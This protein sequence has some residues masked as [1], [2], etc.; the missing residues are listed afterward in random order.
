MSEFRMPSLGADM[1]SGTL[2]EW[3]IRPGERV[4]RGQ[5]VCVVET[6][7]GAIDVEI[8]ETGTVER[9]VAEEGQKVPV[10]EVLAVIIAEGE[11]AEG[12]KA[13]GEAAGR[14]TP[15]EPSIPE[16]SRTPS[17][18]APSPRALD[19][20]PPVPPHAAATSGRL[21]ISPAA[22]KRAAELGLDPADV[23]GSGVDGSITLEDVERA[24]RPAEG[25]Q[26]ALSER[27]AD[28]HAA[29][30][31]AIAT[32]MARSKREIPHYYLGNT[33]CV[34]PALAWLEAHNAERPVAERLIFPVL[35]LR[36]VA[37]ALEAVPALN[38]WF[39]DDAFQP[40][41]G[42]HP[43]VAIALRGGGLVAPALHDADR[44]AP[45]A[46][47]AALRD[48]LTRARQDRL[49]SSELTTAGLTVT[50]LGDLGVESVQGVIYPPQVA[51]VGF[52]RISERPWVRDGQVVAARCLHASLAAD[53]RVTDGALGARFLTRLTDLLTEP[54]RLWPT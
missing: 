8:W 12:E 7:K 36:A 44:L 53:H 16:A 3:N 24:A 10:G 43:G 18:H 39:V 27:A 13:E 33:L 48:L 46:M 20:S 35:Q 14:E 38:G 29:M 47:M 34:E 15:A 21:R 2:V 11:R 32:A 9:L 4:E 49:R 5:I 26:A 40:A 45:D 54:E 28:A 41:E 30:R 42:V 51:L 1:E 50:N 25:R 19:V 31:Q 6:Q 52:G 22:R 17:P 37:L 23:R